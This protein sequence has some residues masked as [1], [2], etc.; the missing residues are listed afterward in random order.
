MSKKK[1]V[2]EIHGFYKGYDIRWLRELPEH[3]DFKL[4]DEFDKL[5]V[6]KGVNK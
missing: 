1:E 3:P 4:V 2:K 6:K 5:N